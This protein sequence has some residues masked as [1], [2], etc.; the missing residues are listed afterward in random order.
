MPNDLCALL[1]QAWH[2]ATNVSHATSIDRTLKQEVHLIDSACTELAKNMMWS[3]RPIDASP[4]IKLRENLIGISEQALYHFRNSGAQ[5][6]DIANAIHYINQVFAM[7]VIWDNHKWFEETLMTLLEVA[8]P[9]TVLSGEAIHF[10]HTLHD[11]IKQQL[12]LRNE[13]EEKTI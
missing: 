7:P 13:N 5:E 10:A 4:M 2:I 8:Y 3:S 1:L 12:S 6:S 9:N 11:G